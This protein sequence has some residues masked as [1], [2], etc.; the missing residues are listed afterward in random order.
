MGDDDEKIN[1]LKK[2]QITFSKVELLGM[3]W[4]PSGGM[5]YEWPPNK[6][7]AT[8]FTGKQ[9]NETVLFVVIWRY[10]YGSIRTDLIKGAFR[11]L[12]EKSTNENAINN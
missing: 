8:K 10:G 1:H 12:H 7:I 5:G 11:K 4:G 6:S 3:L 9:K 2:K